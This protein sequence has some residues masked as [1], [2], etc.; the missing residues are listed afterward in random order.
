M[1]SGGD[2]EVAA[3]ERPA[4]FDDVVLDGVQLM[5]ALSLRGAPRDEALVM[6]VQAWQMIMWSYSP[7]WSE[8]VDAARLRAAFTALA[9]DVEVWPTP[10]MALKRLPG[11]PQAPLLP[12]PIPTTEQRERSRVFVEQIRAL[13]AKWRK[14]GG[15]EI[16]KG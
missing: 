10:A 15:G 14:G 13:C 3:P 4:W 2:R 6:A 16:P 8:D 7:T 11:R 5:A 12:R 1:T 9:R